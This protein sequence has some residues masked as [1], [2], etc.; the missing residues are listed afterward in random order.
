MKRIHVPIII[1]IA[2]CG[3]FAVITQWVLMANNRTTNLGETLIRF[4]C[5][6]TILSNVLVSS[7]STG[8]LLH[9]HRRWRQWAERPGVQTA[10]TVYILVVGLVY[11]SILRFLWSPVGLQWWVDECLHSLIPLLF[12]IH[13]LLFT[14]K[15]SLSYRMIPAWLVFPAIYISLIALYGA[16]SGWYPYPFINVSSIGY[17]RAILH[18]ALLLLTFTS[19]S[20]L[21]IWIAGRIKPFNH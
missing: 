4:F 5:F 14:P 3:W 2:V 18:T 7:V 17:P 20:A 15:T 13:W 8:W 1:G 21:L 12:L 16:V 6:F 9:P 10:I 11:N 19:L